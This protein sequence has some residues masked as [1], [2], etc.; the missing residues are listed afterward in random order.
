MPLLLALSFACSLV[1]GRRFQ[2]N[3]LISQ[4]I[5]ASESSSTSNESPISVQ[6]EKSHTYNGKQDIQR[7]REE[8]IE[9]G[10]SS[11][12]E[13]QQASN[14]I[15]T[16]NAAPAPA[17]PTGAA[18][19]PA[20][21]PV[22]P[23]HSSDTESHTSFQHF[24]NFA[25]M[26]QNQEPE[27]PDCAKQCQGQDEAGDCIQLCQVKILSFRGPL[28]HLSRPVLG[29]LVA[30]GPVAFCLLVYVSHGQLRKRFGH[31]NTRRQYTHNGR[32][33]YEWDQTAKVVALYIKTPEGVTKKDLDISIC[34][35]H[36]RVGRKGKASFLREETFELV[37][38]DMSS[39]SLRNDGELQIFL[40]KVHKAEWPV[41]L[42]HGDLR[43]AV[44]NSKSKP[45]ISKTHEKQMIS[46][47]PVLVS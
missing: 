35:R 13:L 1:V 39:W 15:N 31:S 41:V 26:I 42:L 47:A 21:A 43:S 22:L 2:P 38:E 24:A 20:P 18:D 12:S 28:R 17:G 7:S 23:G 5:Q 25:S 45:A 44:S 30:F 33:V 32:I 34:A 3:V 19:A 11:L 46:S 14:K 27:D 4:K 29:I 16:T 37:N 9:S 40:H 8:L 10:A 36:L 6:T